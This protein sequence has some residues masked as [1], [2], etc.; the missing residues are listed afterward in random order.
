MTRNTKNS[1]KTADFVDEPPVLWMKEQ[2]RDEFLNLMIDMRNQ[3][4]DKVPTSFVASAL[5]QR[6]KKRD[7]RWDALTKDKQT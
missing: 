4:D 6:L 2:M 1:K 3:M 7:V 5:I